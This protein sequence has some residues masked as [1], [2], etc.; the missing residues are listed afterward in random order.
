[1][2]LGHDRLETALNTTIYYFNVYQY[3]RNLP[4]SLTRFTMVRALK[5]VTINKLINRVN[6]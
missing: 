2:V 3:L 1:M 6:Y 5:K 4:T